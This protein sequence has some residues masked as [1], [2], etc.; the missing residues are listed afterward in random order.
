MRR[1]VIDPDVALGLAEYVAK[2]PARK[3]LVAPNLLTSQVLVLPFSEVQR[4][5]MSRQEADR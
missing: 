2:A 3:H 4:G 1:Y 5:Q